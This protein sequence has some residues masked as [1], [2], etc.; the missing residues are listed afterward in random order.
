MS[1]WIGC[2]GGYVFWYST[3]HTFAGMFDTTLFSKNAVVVEEKEN[4]ALH[5]I[6]LFITTIC[7]ASIDNNSFSTFRR[8][9]V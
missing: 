4:A 2:F 1:E 6:V 7:Y 8:S 5:V 3:L 9:P